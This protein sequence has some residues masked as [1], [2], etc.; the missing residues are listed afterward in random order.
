MAQIKQIAPLS[1]LRSLGKGFGCEIFLLDEKEGLLLKVVEPGPRASNAARRIRNEWDILRFRDIPGV[2]RVLESR[3]VQQREALILDYIPGKTLYEVFSIGPLAI[4]TF[5]EIAIGAARALQSIHQSGIIHRNLT[6]G[7]L[8]IEDNSKRV[9]LTGF[10]LATK[11]DRPE[12]QNNIFKEFEISDLNYAAP[13]QSGRSHHVVSELSDLYSLGL[14][15]FEAISGQLPFESED[16]LE[17]MH[18]QGAKLPPELGALRKDIPPAISLLIS[19]LLEK[20]P[21]R[22]YQ[23][24]SQ[25]LS[26]LE[27]CASQWEESGKIALDGLSLNRMRAEPV[28]PNILLEREEQLDLLEELISQSAGGQLSVAMIQGEA[29]TGKTSL[30]NRVGRSA[31]RFNYTV[32]KCAADAYQSH[33]PYQAIAQILSTFTE[34][35]LSRTSEEAGYWRDK[36]EAEL[37]E[38]G[39]VLGRISPSFKQIAGD[40]HEL[41]SLD[42]ESALNRLRFAFRKL[43]RLIADDEYPLLIIVDD[44]HLIDT[45]SL[46]L[47]ESLLADTRISHFVLLGLYRA[48]EKAMENGFSEKLLQ[49][50][51][52]DL[53]FHLVEIGSLSLESIKELLGLTYGE[54][55]DGLDSLG[56]II[57]NKTKGNPLYMQQLLRALVDRKMLSYDEDRHLWSWSASEIEAM[58]LLGSIPD[59]MKNRLDSLQPEI[60]QLLSRAACFG[61]RFHFKALKD[62]F[63]QDSESLESMLHVAVDEEVLELLNSNGPIRQNAFAFIHPQMRDI[64]YSL[65][66]ISQKSKSHVAIGHWLYDN[67]SDEERVANLFEIATQY[68]RGQKHISDR[69][70]RIRAAELNLAAGEQ[71]KLSAA[72][73]QAYRYIKN[74][75]EFLPPDA[76]ATNYELTLRLHNE[77]VRLAAVNGNFLVLEKYKEEL[78]KNTRHQ[79]DQEELYRTLIRANINKKELTEAVKYGLEYLAK[80]GYKFPAKP[81]QAHV[82]AG[83]ADISLRLRGKSTDALA[84]LPKMVNEQAAS[85]MRILAQTSVA[86]YFAAQNLTPLIIFRALKLTLKYGNTPESS[87]AYAAFGYIHSGALGNY[88]KGFEFGELGVKIAGETEQNEMYVDRVFIHNIFTRHWVEPASEVMKALDWVYEKGLETGNIEDAA[89][90]AHSYIYFSFYQGIQLSDLSEKSAQYEASVRLLNQPSTL[91]RINMYQQAI[92]NLRGNADEPALLKGA[93]YNED[94]MLPLHESDTILIATHNLYFLKTFLNYLFARYE[95]AHNA[96]AKTREYAEAAVASYFVPLFAYLESLL[97]FSDKTSE[98]KAL[99]QN[100]KLLKKCAATSPENYRHRYELVLAE[101]SRK[102]GQA[103]KARLLYEDA[104]AGARRTANKLDEAMASELA[105]SFHM[106]LGHPERGAKLLRNSYRLFRNWGA[107]AKMRQMEMRYGSAL[108]EA[109]EESFAITQSTLGADDTLDYLSLVKTLQAMSTEVD[110]R[111]LLEKMM[112]VVLE[113]AGSDRGLLILEKNEKWEVVAERD[114]NNSKAAFEQNLALSEAGELLPLEIVRSVISNREPILINDATSAHKFQDIN[115]LHSRKVLSML[116]MPLIKQERLIGVIFLENSLAKG[117][118]SDRIQQGLNM[119]CGQFAISIDNSRLYEDLGEKVEQ[120]QSLL[121]SLRDKVDEQER[122]LNVFS[123][124]VPEPVVRR[125]LAASEI[126]PDEG[127]VRDV[128]VMFCDIRDFTPLSEELAPNDVVSFLNEFYSV[129]TEIIHRNHGTVNQFI[130]DE[131]FAAFGAP[132]ASAQNEINAIRCALEMREAIPELNDRFL[133]KFGKGVRIGIGLNKGQVV[134]G[135]MGSKS[136]LAYSVVGDT[137]NTCKRIESLTKSMTNGILVSDSVYEKCGD[138]IQVTPWDPVPVKGKKGTIRVYELHGFAA[139]DASS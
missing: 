17:L 35:V 10:G 1:T 58:S 139:E 34:F 70:E 62:L 69:K 11:S 21:E 128:T 55:I 80:L 64:T 108:L 46:T 3:K 68:N 92:E 27:Y 135:N 114:L 61:E 112:R 107:T 134:T 65:L 79:V 90:G 2:R 136:K 7:H 48:D 81:T 123:Q 77:G 24:A 113:N 121:A 32:L 83:L 122:T 102:K 100:I 23:S 19:K 50:K 104:I 127:E 59:L 93:Y 63:E 5:I 75:L 97:F 106:G 43:V 8:L 57:L 16:P 78:E 73:R 22:R 12:D 47:L 117:A 103:D 129:M 99:K 94:E 9:V 29:G 51:V 95:D 6:P 15:L 28:I 116:A 18:L 37:G 13:E 118:F 125:T 124:F 89:Y 91:Y 101:R 110:F 119:L 44:I 86:T 60:R 109:G 31:G 26:D 120:N 87:F 30:A 14:V 45:G 96:A 20:D 84:G 74:G 130:G 138:Q 36:I 111:S 42:D 38:M 40:Q 115:Y 49:L 137:V 72:H 131:I 132:V 39:A 54:Q 76:W 85:A 67:Y 41:P 52:S 53:P 105:G 98:D 88:R 126:R 71:A 133:K 66:D 82:V 25:L 33:I 4:P 56:E